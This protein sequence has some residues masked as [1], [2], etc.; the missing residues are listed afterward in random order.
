MP[1]TQEAQRVGELGAVLVPEVRDDDHERAAG[2]AQQERARGGDVVRMRGRGLD[3]VELADQAVERVSP[4]S[5][6]DEAL[7]AG[8]VPKVMAP[9][10]SPPP[11]THDSMTALS[12][13]RSGVALPRR[14]VERACGGRNP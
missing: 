6:R 13:D 3:V 9:T 2:L 1:P 8:R 7:L 14:Y 5:W 4:F 11:A 12:T 10:A